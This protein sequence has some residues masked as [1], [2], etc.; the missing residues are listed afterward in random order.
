MLDARADDSLAS[1]GRLPPRYAVRPAV[2]CQQ[3]SNDA[4]SDDGP[5][6][7]ENHPYSCSVLS[8]V[9]VTS[10]DHFQDVRLIRFSLP[11]EK[12]WYVYFCRAFFNAFSNCRE[13]LAGACAFQRFFG[14]STVDCSY[15]ACVT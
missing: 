9:R 4:V 7:D 15:R 8:N 12:V 1:L 14:R 3:E 10:V 6:Y 13:I 2:D 11:S 5:P